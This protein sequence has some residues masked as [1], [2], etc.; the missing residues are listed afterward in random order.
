MGIRKHCAGC[1][2]DSAAV[3]TQALYLDRSS[4]DQRSFEILESTG[5]FK[6]R[7]IVSHGG[8]PGSHTGS[9]TGISSVIR[10]PKDF[11]LKL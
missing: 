11:F 5:D 1:E 6:S 2:V 3:Y 10:N 9:S 8:R 7:E 4:K